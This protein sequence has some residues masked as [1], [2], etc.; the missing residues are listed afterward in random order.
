MKNINKAMK[1]LS[2]AAG[3]RERMWR[4]ESKSELKIAKKD[5]GY[6]DKLAKMRE[7]NIGD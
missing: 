6:F 2:K 4:K 5:P 1:E 3:T 7:P